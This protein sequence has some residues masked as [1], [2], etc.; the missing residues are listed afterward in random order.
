MKEKAEPN[1]SDARWLNRMGVEK[2]ESFWQAKG[3][4]KCF[5]TGYIGRT[6]IFEVC[7]FDEPV[8]DLV[9]SGCDEATLRNHFRESGIRSLFQDGMDKVRDGITTVAEVRRL[10]AKNHDVT[11]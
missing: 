5:D 1:E 2:P 8:Y 11:P 4:E 10:G 9:L 3:C 7:P 6:G